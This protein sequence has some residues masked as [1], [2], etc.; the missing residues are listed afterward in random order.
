MGPSSY[1]STMKI[2][3]PYFITFVSVF[4]S[5]VCAQ[6]PTSALPAI[7][8]S[9]DSATNQ[10]PKDNLVIVGY[11]VEETINM[12]FG[13]SVTQYE[14]SHLSLVATR[15]LGPNNTRVVT[16][17]YGKPKVKR[18]NEAASLASKIIVD[19]PSVAIHPIDLDIIAPAEP[20]KPVPADAVETNEKV[21]IRGS[22]TAEMLM[23]VADR[24]YFVGDLVTAV[25]YYEEL[26]RMDVMLDNMYYYR[27]AQSLKGLDQNQKANEAMLLFESRNTGNNVVKHNK[28]VRN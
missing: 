10:K 26:L 4:C 25:K 20:S 2:Y 16:P 21:V 11:Y 7:I 23:K 1:Y 12:V 8:E 3:A 9:T 13:R 18:I 14:V 28:L 15:D 27:Y 19:T 5:S 22:K 24:A 17:I 6:N